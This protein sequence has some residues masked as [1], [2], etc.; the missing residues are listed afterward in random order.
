MAETTTSIPP[1]GIG[2]LHWNDLLKG[3]IK[4][5]S[6]LI[7][8]I[9]IKTL[10]DKSIPSYAEIEPLL[11]AVVYFFVGYLGINAATNNVGQMF[12]QD[13]PVVV[14]GAEK[15]ENLQQKADDGPAKI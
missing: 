5:S 2:R 4:S 14:V 1:S 11:E 7:V 13:K 8:G 12:T 6:G 9:L 3:L 15:L 10:Q